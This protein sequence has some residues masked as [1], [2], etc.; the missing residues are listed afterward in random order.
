M[1]DA[2]PT[3]RLRMR[4]FVGR[5]MID[6]CWLPQTLPHVAGT[7]HRAICAAAEA[8]GDQW[9]LELFDPDEPDPEAAYMRIGSAASLMVRPVPVDQWPNLGPD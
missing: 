7:R 6:E 9:M 4:L 2:G 5:V 8:M 1:D 3:P